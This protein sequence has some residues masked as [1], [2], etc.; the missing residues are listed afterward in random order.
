VVY[1]GSGIAGYGDLLIVRHNARYLSAYGHNEALLARE[2]ETV[3][4]GQIIARRG[5]S[6]TNSVKLHFEVRRDGQPV[7]PLA[8]LPPR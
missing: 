2:G 6:G 4:A 7:D 5:S 8:L 3:A 1:A